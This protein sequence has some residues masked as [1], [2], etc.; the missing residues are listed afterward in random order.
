VCEDESSKL[1]KESVEKTLSQLRQK[2]Q[3]LSAGNRDNVLI[4]K[5]FKQFDV[6]KDK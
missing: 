1:A 3:V 2:L 4:G 6:S 5:L